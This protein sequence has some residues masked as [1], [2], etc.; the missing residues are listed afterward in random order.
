MA[1]AMPLSTSVSSCWWS[2][3][4]RASCCAGILVARDMC[5]MD[6]ASR[7]RVGTGLPEGGLSL[8]EAARTP[9]LW[10][11]C[12]INFLVMNCLLTIVIH[13][14]PHASDIGLDPIKAASVVSTVGGVSMLGR[15]LTGLLVDRVGTRKS[16]TTCFIL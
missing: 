12:I 9:Q 13:V 11:F 1:G 6:T 15:L 16:I 8:R 3:S 5:W 2:L 10:M 4:A 14:V 7:F